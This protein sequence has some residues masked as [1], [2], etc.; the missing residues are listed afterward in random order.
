MNNFTNNII[1]INN[2]DENSRNHLLF[3]IE[4]PSGKDLFLSRY[5][6]QSRKD[7]GLWQEQLLI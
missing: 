1:I 3:A 2:N 5:T 4:R 7:S 6:E